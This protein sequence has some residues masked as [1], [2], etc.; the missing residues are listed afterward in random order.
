MVREANNKTFADA[1]KENMTNHI[2]KSVVSDKETDATREDHSE[3]KNTNVVETN[4]DSFSQEDDFMEYNC[5]LCSFQTDTKMR[6]SRHMQRIHRSKPTQEKCESCGDEFSNKTELNKHIASKHPKMRICRFYLEKRCRYG[7]EDCFYL[8]ERK[9][10]NNFNCN[11]CGKDFDMKTDM[12]MHRK[13][14]HL[15]R[16]IPCRNF[17]KDKNIC[18]FEDDECWY[19]HE[20]SK[21]LDFQSSRQKTRKK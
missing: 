15:D 11:M 3:N 6:I 17:F 20:L 12:M 7:D 19:R 1:T 2:E 13:N 14:D 9:A 10:E 21:S 8:H 18:Q 5:K 16:L 4:D